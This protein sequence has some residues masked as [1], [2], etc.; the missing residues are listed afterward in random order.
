[1]DQLPP[2]GTG[3]PDRAEYIAS[4]ARRAFVL[5]ANPNLQ[6]L[7]EL[8]LAPCASSIFVNGDD[9]AEVAPI[10]V[11]AVGVYEGRPVEG[12]PKPE[13]AE[14]RTVRIEVRRTEQPIL[15]F[16]MSYDP[17]LWEV[18]VAEDASLAAIQLSSHHP[19]A[20]RCSA[21]LSAVMPVLGGPHVHALGHSEGHDRMGPAQLAEQIR[22][23][24]GLPLTSFQ[25]NYYG[26]S[27]T[28]PFYDD[29]PLIRAIV[30]EHRQQ[31]RLH[32]GRPPGSFPVIH[33]GTVMR[34]GT[35]AA[36]LALPDPLI[37]AVTY[38]DADQAWYGITDHELVKFDEQSR[39]EKIVAT[40]CERLSWLGGITYD[41]KRR[42]IL[43]STS[44]HTGVHH[45]YDPLGRTWDTVPLTRTRG[46]LHGLAYEPERD[47]IFAV[48]TSGLVMLTPE[49]APLCEV[50]RLP[51]LAVG[52]MEPTRPALQ[53]AAFRDAVV[54]CAGNPGTEHQAF[55]SP[56]SAPP[57]ARGWIVSPATAE[58]IL[59]DVDC[60]RPRGAIREEPPAAPFPAGF[61]TQSWR[62]EVG[63]FEG[64]VD[65]HDLRY[66]G[67][68]VLAQVAR[69]GAPL[70]VNAPDGAAMLVRYEAYRG[71]LASLDEV[72]FPDWQQR[73]ARAKHEIADRT[74]VP[75]DALP[76]TRIEDPHLHWTPQAAEDLAAI[77]AGENRGA[78]K[79]Q[80]LAHV[81]SG[82]GS[83]P[84]DGPFAGFHAGAHARIRFVLHREP[85]GVWIAYVR[86]NASAS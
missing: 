68:E 71:L 11:H 10:E 9:T 47:V 7:P 67:R 28:I 79:S 15:L 80:F 24:N 52:P 57:V 75:P 63:E 54:I 37:K 48:A 86:E 69:T 78:L 66:H 6:A 53:M 61:A 58:V 59:L 60:I 25:G 44:W 19:S 12:R 3:D 42:R 43:V 70:M 36:P 64:R 55:F 27:F 76:R 5:D 20:V 65:L 29:P 26:E 21:V 14:P 31:L 38:C 41:S 23:L 50:T 83:A 85:D 34:Y 1:M 40:G 46:A 73:L 13:P 33:E 17:V 74:S 45:L 18:D 56:E 30:A 39:V 16:L 4:A 32:R 35:R 77:A 49:L 51:N 81:A 8:F 82:V 62:S 2:H 72:T 84:M 22:I